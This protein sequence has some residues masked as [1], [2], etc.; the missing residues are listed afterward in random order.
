LTDWVFSDSYIKHRSL[1]T[2]VSIIELTH[3]T[4]ETS[5]TL[6]LDVYRLANVWLVILFW[7]CS[8]KDWVNHPNKVLTATVSLLL[9]LIFNIRLNKISAH[10]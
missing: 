1:S 6:H 4:Q 7:H 10:S 3:T 8:C 2:N 9:Y 5:K